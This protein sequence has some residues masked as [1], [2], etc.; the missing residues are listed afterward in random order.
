[1]NAK[2]AKKQFG[3]KGTKRQRKEW[4][5]ATVRGK[6]PNL[7]VKRVP[8]LNPDKKLRTKAEKIEERIKNK[9]S[10]HLVL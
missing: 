3:T 5:K 8:N 6:V 1:M 2:Q 4:Q 9:V 7:G 10:K